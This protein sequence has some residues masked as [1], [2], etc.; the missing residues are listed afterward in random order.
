MEDFITS[1]EINMLTIKEMGYHGNKLMEEF[2]GECV[3][4]CT[5][6]GYKHIRA[7]KQSGESERRKSPLKTPCVK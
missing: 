4:S 3:L 7:K 2:L 6:N 1:S 5:L